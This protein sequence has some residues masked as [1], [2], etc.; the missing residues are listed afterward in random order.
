MAHDYGRGCHRKVKELTRR[1]KMEKADDGKKS[2]RRKKLE[3]EAIKV[4]ELASTSLPKL[5]N[6]L[7]EIEEK[8]IPAGRNRNQSDKELNLVPHRRDLRGYRVFLVA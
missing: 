2:L 7:N 6:A 8:F 5:E 1:A 4:E 3:A